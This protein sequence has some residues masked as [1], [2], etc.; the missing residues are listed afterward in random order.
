MEKLLALLKEC[1]EDVFV[2]DFKEK[3]ELHLTFDDFEG[4]DDDWNEI[5]REYLNPAAVEKVFDYIEE[6]A[7]LISGGLYQQYQLDNYVI[8]IGFTS[9]SFG[10]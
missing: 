7:N 8:E 10:I 2:D 6:N 9:T 3:K 5:E 4:F 1:G